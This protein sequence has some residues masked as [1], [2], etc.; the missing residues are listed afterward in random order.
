MT[1]PAFP[2]RSS[3]IPRL[4]ELCISAAFS[5]GNA[6]PD[7]NGIHHAS[8]H[9]YHADTTVHPPRHPFPD[10]TLRDPLRSSVPLTQ[11]RPV[12]SSRSARAHSVQFMEH[13]ECMA[14][15][16]G[17]GRALPDMEFRSRMYGSICEFRTIAAAKSLI[18]DLS[19]HGHFPRLL[20]P[21]LR[22][23]PH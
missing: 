17:Y 3:L 7:E 18:P 13:Q 2:P 22:T 20:D 19:V 15:S 9:R 16:Q 6:R 10:H 4:L 11:I 8:H 5:S 12:K 21:S 1:K 23:D 14:G